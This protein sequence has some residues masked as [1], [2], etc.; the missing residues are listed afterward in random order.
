MNTDRIKMCIIYVYN[1][2]SPEIFKNPSTGLKLTKMIQPNTDSSKSVGKLNVLEN[3][4]KK[5][6]NLGCLYRCLSVQLLMV[7]IAEQHCRLLA[8]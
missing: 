8:V 5:K 3:V 7:L 4:L 1:R 6:V 2:S